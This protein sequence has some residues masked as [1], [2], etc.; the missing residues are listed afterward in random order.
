[1]EFR[2]KMRNEALILAP[3]SHLEWILGSYDFPIIL[4][5]ST[6]EEIILASNIDLLKYNSNETEYDTIFF[7]T[8]SEVSHTNLQFAR[9]QITLKCAKQTEEDCK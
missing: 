4:I 3:A 9:M 2:N 7:E 6:S 5:K 1:M 8:I